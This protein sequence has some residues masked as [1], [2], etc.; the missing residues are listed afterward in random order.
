M[1]RT[2]FGMRLHSRSTHRVRAPCV[3]VPTRPFSCSNIPALTQNGRGKGSLLLTEFPLSARYSQAPELGILTVL[4]T[5]SCNSHCSH[6]QILQF[7]LQLDLLTTRIIYYGLGILTTACYSHSQIRILL[8]ESDAVLTARESGISLPGGRSYLR[9]QS[10][11]ISVVLSRR[12]PAR[13]VQIVII[14]SVF[15]CFS[16]FFALFT[17]FSR[18]FDEI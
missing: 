15:T 12:C 13:I 9:H 17:V 5:R 18:L 7:A 16:Q 2:I 4:T 14:L 1:S 10:A 8:S 3:G 11:G 6:Y